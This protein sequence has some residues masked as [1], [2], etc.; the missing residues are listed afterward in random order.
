VRI[1]IIDDQPA[2][3]LVVREILESEGHQA[4]LATSGEEGLRLIEAEPP[5]AVFLDVVMPGLDGIE[6]L[7]RIRDRR[8]GL[9]VII[10]SGW[11]SAEQRRAAWELGVVDVLQKP[12][13]IQEFALALARVRSA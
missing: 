5:D 1:L 10:L 7:R 13:P 8:P 11:M 4:I 9:P 2:L 12:A 6:T 3:G